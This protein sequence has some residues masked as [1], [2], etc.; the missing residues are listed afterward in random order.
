VCKIVLG[1][2]KYYSNAPENIERSRKNPTKEILHHEYCHES[3][4]DATLCLNWCEVSEIRPVECT[5]N[6]GGDGSGLP[7]T[8][9]SL[10]IVTCLNCF[11]H[12][13]ESR[14]LDGSCLEHKQILSN[15]HSW[16][17]CINYVYHC[18]S[19]YIHNYPQR[20]LSMNLRSLA[21][22]KWFGVT[23]MILGSYEIISS[24]W[25]LKLF[26]QSCKNL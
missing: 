22:G 4:K 9:L 17:C 7:D 23:L 18:V 10:N 26:S 13:C 11:A 21:I 6:K 14:R 19:L 20:S 25:F 8:K 16:S 12:S 1:S 3:C 24:Q 15:S 2:W 5:W